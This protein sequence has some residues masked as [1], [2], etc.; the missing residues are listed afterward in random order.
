MRSRRSII[1]GNKLQ[2][3]HI[4]PVRIRIPI[5]RE[6]EIVADIKKYGLLNVRR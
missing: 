2:K 1:S 3:I 5:P 4:L 6:A